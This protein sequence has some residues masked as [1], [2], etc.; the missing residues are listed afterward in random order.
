MHSV[1][2]ALTA[3]VLPDPD[4]PKNKKYDILSNF[5]FKTGEPNYIPTNS[6]NADLN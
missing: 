6:A 1:A 3:K 5:S 2:K 4:G